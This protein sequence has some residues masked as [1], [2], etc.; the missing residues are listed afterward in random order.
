MR[1]HSS[2]NL[3]G[4]PT[5]TLKRRNCKRSKQRIEPFSLEE[6]PVVAMADQ[7]TMAELL[8]APIEGYGD[9]IV[10]PAI[11]VE[12][13]ELKHGLLNLVTSKLFYGF[14]KEDLH[15]HIRWF[16]KISS[17]IKYKDDLLRACPHH[18]FTELHQLN[19]FYNALTPTDQDSLNAVAGESTNAPSSSSS[20]TPHNPEISALVDAVK[21]MLHQKSPPPAS[22]IVVE[23][24]CVTCAAAVNY[25]QGN[26]EYSPRGVA[27]QIRPSGFAQPNQTQVASSNELLN[28]KKINDANMKAMQNQINNVKNELRNEMQTSI[29]TSM[30]NQTNE[31]KNMMAS[32][33]QMNTAS[34]SG[35]GPLPSN[36]VANPRGDLKAITTRSDRSTTS[37]SGIADDVIVKVGKFHFLADFVVFDYVVDPRVPL[38]TERPFLRMERTLIDVYGEELTL[39]VDDEA[40]TFKGGQTSRYSYNDAVSIN[41]IDVIDIACEEYAP[42]VLRFSL[43]S[44]SDNPTPSIDPILST[45]PPSFTP[46]EGGDFVLEEIKACLT[47]D[48]IPPGIDDTDFDPEGDLLLLEKLLNNDPSSP[49]PPKELHVEELKIIKSSIDD[50]PELELKDLPSHL[51]YAFLEGTDKLPFI[52]PKDLKED[53]KVRLLK[54]GDPKTHEVIKNE[55]IK[56]LNAGLIYA[57]SVSPWVSPVMTIVENDYDELILTRLVTGWRVCIDYKKLNDATRKDHFPLPFMDQLLE[58]LAG[59]EFYCF[60]DGFLGYFQIPIDPQDQEK[61]TFTCPYGTFSYQRMPFSLCNAPGIESEANTSDFNS[62]KS[63]SSV[64]NEPKGLSQP[65]IWNDAPIIEEYELDSDDECV[66][67]PSL[68]QEK[69]SFAYVN[70]TKHVKSPRESVKNQ[71]TFSQSPKVDKRDWNGLMSKRLGLGYGFTKKTCFVCGSLSHLIRDCDFYEKRMARQAELNKKMGKGTGQMEDR[72]VWNNVQRVNLQNKFVPS[73]DKAVSAVGGIRETAVK[74]IAYLA[75]YQDYNGSPVAFGGNKGYIT[76]KGKIK[77]GKLDFKDVYLVKELQDF[78]LFFVSQICDKKNKVL[79][80][81]TGCLVLSPDLT[82]P[83]ENQVLLKIPRENNMYSFNLEN[84]V[85]SG[86]LACLITK[87]TINESNKW[88][89]RLE[90]KSRDMIEFYRSKGIKREYSNARTPQQNGVAE[91][92]NTTLIEAARTMLADSFLPITFWAEAVSTTCYVLNKVLVTKPH[93]KTPYELITGKIPIIS[94]VRTFGCHVTIMNTI[95]HLGKFDGKSDEGFLVGYSLNSKAFRVYNLVTKRVE[96]NL[97]INF[98]KKKPNVAGKGPNWLFD[99]DY[100][101]DLMNY[102][103]VTA[104][105]KANKTATESAQ[106]YFGLPIWSSYSSTVKSSKAKKAYEKDD[107]DTGSESNEEPEDHVSEV[108]L[109]ELERLKRQ[110]KEAEVE[111]HRKEFAQ[112]TEDLLLQA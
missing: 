90:F 102:Q 7:R 104:E 13:F 73:T 5:T 18:C 49:L 30:S 112:S 79:F 63:N 59:N 54:T 88:H 87:A 69:P 96:E 33:S 107:E 19:T 16:N 35:S 85:P 77:N 2:S 108:F 93:N 76:G 25:N 11:L 12:N 51:E 101:T 111:I 22:V 28:Y 8:Q 92:K 50:P 84:I 56:L 58:R 97:H 55:V 53:E 109:E 83:D 74:A 61:T 64:V 105:N 39:R 24:I 45:Y 81:D 60:L 75:E 72:P 23:D 40:L 1:T 70:T 34:T 44:K 36:T 62:C 82:L 99:L 46:F 67:K 41:R 21:A 27:N 47:N 89:R 3:V 42:E 4:E 106:E 9:A 20:S 94:Y 68:G 32:F 43:I 37:P 52:I 91:R 29:Q 80:T 78:N 103:P 110:E 6:T 48:S 26:S 66:S 17:T 10:I 31:L 95:D 65:K 98:L 38:I 14:K 86:G 71:N 100:L 57:I 15:A